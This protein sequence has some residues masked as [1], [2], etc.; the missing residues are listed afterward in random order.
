MNEG[1]SEVHSY[2]ITSNRLSNISCILDILTTNKLAPK[3]DLRAAEY[4][5][6]YTG[7][8]DNSSREGSSILELDWGSKRKGSLSEGRFD[9]VP[10]FQ[11]LI[12]IP[13]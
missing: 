12:Y 1:R 2:I 7:T 13:V 3:F 9:R 6:R 10:A 11:E 4:Y 8:R 5:Y